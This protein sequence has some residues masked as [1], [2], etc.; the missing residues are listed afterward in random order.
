MCGIGVS[1]EAS[2]EQTDVGD[3]GLQAMSCPREIEEKPTITLALAWSL[4]RYFDMKVPSNEVYF[5]LK[6]TGLNYLLN[7]GKTRSLSNV[8]KSRFLDQVDVKFLT[9]C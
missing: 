4:E 9:L 1:C 7:G 8:M 3:A 2:C 6:R 5:V